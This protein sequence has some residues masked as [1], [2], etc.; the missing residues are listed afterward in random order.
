[1]V[2][3]TRAH[4]RIAHRAVAGRR[5]TI[6]DV[7]PRPVEVLV[8]ATAESA[9]DPDLVIHFLGPAWLAM[10][11]ADDLR[12]PIVIAVVNLGAGSGVYARPFADGAA[13]DRLIAAIETATGKRFAHRYLTGFSAGYGAIRSILRTRYGSVDG[14]LLLD[15]IHTSYVPEGKTLAAGGTL[16]ESGLDVFRKLAA[17]A[18]A[19]KKRF[20]ITHSEIFPGTYASTTETTD[21]L[22]RS[23]GLK[24]VPVV[25]WGPLGM[26]QLSGTRAGSFAVLGFAGNSA[27]D[28]V[29]HLHAMG[30]FLKMLI[31][32]GYA[33]RASATR[34]PVAFDR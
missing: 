7:L 28:H 1:M 24:R 14:V 34:A 15:G 26:Q 22:L 19:E 29:D 27:P 25:A 13:Y 17:D 6:A 30:H 18:V 8:T 23:V 32:P 5:V 21:F 2:D 31:E 3:T 9:G 11:A 4:E 33:R 12:R 16:D 10:Q 20:V